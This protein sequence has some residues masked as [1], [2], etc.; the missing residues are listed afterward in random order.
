MKNHI[1]IDV[2]EPDEFMR[3]HVR[4][5]VNIPPSE[6]MTGSPKLAGVAKDA[7]LI[8]YCVSGSR[9]NVSSHILRSM[10]Y[11]NITNGMNR[12]YVESRILPTL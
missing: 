5:A 9:S 2:R 7:A 6:L 8:L 11:T 10:G 1:I 12:Q 4:G 3:G